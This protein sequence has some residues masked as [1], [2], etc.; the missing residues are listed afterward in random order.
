M[1]S[2]AGRIGVRGNTGGFLS[3]SAPTVIR[4]RHFTQISDRRLMKLT[5]K[6]AKF[7]LLRMTLCL[8]LLRLVFVRNPAAP[9]MFLCLYCDVFIYLL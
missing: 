9:L 6:P 2:S 4:I 5:E 1:I 7:M 3:E 8:W